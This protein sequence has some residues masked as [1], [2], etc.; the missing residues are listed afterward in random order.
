[1]TKTDGATK[2]AMGLLAEGLP[3]LSSSAREFVRHHPREARLAVTVALET[4]AAQ[5]EAEDAGSAVDVPE[6][7]R[8]FVVPR[9]G[10]GGIL[11]V[12]AAASPAGGVAHHGLRVGGEEGRCLPGGRPSA[13]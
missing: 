3:A 7:L 1:M 5:R 4:A 13:G 10:G 12:S 2:E 9:T 6:W 8:A 11:G